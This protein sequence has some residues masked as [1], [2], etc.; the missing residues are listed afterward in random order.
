MSARWVSSA[1]RPS[2]STTKWLPTRY[3]WCGLWVMKTTP[4]P[5][6][7]ALTMYFSTTPDWFTPSAAVGSSRISTLAPKW[8]AR[9]IATHWR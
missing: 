4:I 5:A 9:A 7:R 3:A 8:I 2:L 1:T 6:S